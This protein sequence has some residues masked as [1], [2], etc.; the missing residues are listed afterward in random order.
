MS[1]DRTTIWLGNASPLGKR[2]RAM[3]REI[4]PVVCG[5]TFSA[6]AILAVVAIT[7]AAAQISIELKAIERA[8]HASDPH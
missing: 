7:V 5:W 2:R 8:V 3:L 4:K 1:D 6:I